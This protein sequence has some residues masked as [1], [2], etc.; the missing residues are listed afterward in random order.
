M[1]QKKKKNLL[2]W[3]GNP[4]Q[5]QKQTINKKAEYSK[6]ITSKKREI[7]LTI[8]KSKHKTNWLVEMSQS[9]ERT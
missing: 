4:Q 1:I 3:N 2:P 5:E 6:E 9:Q 7:K 8:F